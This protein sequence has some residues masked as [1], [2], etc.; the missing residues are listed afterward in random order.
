[1][2]PCQFSFTLL[3]MVK[4]IGFLYLVRG[5]RKE[6]YRIPGFNAFK[7]SLFMI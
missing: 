2:T 5:A 1:M 6:P 4:E 3:G 7:H